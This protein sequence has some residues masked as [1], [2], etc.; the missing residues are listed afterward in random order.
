[1]LRVCQAILGDHDF[2]GNGA[3]DVAQDIVAG[4][5]LR[6][7]M[8]GY[9]PTRG[10]LIPF[11]VGGA[12]KRSYELLWKSRRLMR[13]DDIANP[14]TGDRDDPVLNAQADELASRIGDEIESFPP[15]LKDAIEDL[16]RVPQNPKSEGGKRTSTRYVHRHRAREELRERLGGLVP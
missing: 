5:M 10:P 7:T 3:D 12:R 4:W 6:K 1:V 16:F 13:L 11:L 14:A 15:H 9:D 2:N 8:Q